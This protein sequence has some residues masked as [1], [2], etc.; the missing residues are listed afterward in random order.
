M[1]RKLHSQVTYNGG[2]VELPELSDNLLNIM[3]APCSSFEISSSSKPIQVTNS[4]SFQ[5][6]IFIFKKM[7]P[8]KYFYK[9]KKKE[10]VNTQLCDTYSTPQ[11]APVTSIRAEVLQA[12]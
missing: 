5:T 12:L 2:S 6:S 4:E 8:Q 3:L 11:K 1:K 7:R 9:S 10:Q